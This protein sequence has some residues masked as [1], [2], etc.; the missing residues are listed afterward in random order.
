MLLAMNT[1]ENGG[2][3]CHQLSQVLHRKLLAKFEDF[4]LAQY[5]GR[6]KGEW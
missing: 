4:S 5:L 2:W 3:K 6:L 1:P